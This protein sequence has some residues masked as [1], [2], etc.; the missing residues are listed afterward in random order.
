MLTAA[1]VNEE[2][3]IAGIGFLVI[4][5][6]SKFI[7]AGSS[8]CPADSAV[9][10]DAKVLYFAMQSCTNG[11]QEIKI[12]LSSNEEMVKP[13]NQGYFSEVWRMNIQINIIRECLAYMGNPSMLAVPGRWNRAAYSLALHGLNH[14]EVTLFHQG[15]D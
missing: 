6:Q 4:D 13:V 7:Y 2:L 3:S 5:H 14:H 12:F 9:D 10:A 11:G 15:S 8:C 1:V